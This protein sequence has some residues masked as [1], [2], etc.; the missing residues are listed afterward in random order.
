MRCLARMEQAGVCLDLPYLSELSKELGTDIERLEAEIYQLAG[1]G[2]NIGSPL[3]LQKVLFEELALKTKG[4]TKTGYST[5]ASVLEALK[6]EHP[7][8]AKIL[9]YRQLT[10]LRSTYVDSLPPQVSSRDGRLHGEFNQT[11]TATG[12]LS[13]SN[14]NLQNIPIKTEVGRRIRR[15]FV[16]GGKDHVLLSADYSQIELR[17]LAHM[18]GDANSARCLRK[19]SRHSCAHSRAGI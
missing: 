4:R 6:D 11:T 19:R 18:S 2:F 13:S 10:K 8:V 14:P 12:R 3:Q 7:I 16:P 5:D 15:A 9:E 17:L 1:H